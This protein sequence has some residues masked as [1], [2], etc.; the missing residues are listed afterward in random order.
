MSLN[1]SIFQCYS[2]LSFFCGLVSLI[3]SRDAFL[4]KPNDKIDPVALI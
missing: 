2:L 4:P 1:I 3:C